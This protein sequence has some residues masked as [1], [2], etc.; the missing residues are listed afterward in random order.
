MSLFLISDYDSYGDLGFDYYNMVACQICKQACKEG[1]RIQMV[2]QENVLALSDM[3]VH[4]MDNQ[5]VAWLSLCRARET[6][7]G[8]T[9]PSQ[10]VQ[11]FYSVV[12]IP[13]PVEL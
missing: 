5:K 8:A 11:Q 13:Y 7:W 10:K 3:E 1:K 2:V 9:R 12:G 6:R 4:K